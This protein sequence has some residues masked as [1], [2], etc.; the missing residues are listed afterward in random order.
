[1]VVGAY[2]RDAG[3]LEEVRDEMRR[4]DGVSSEAGRRWRGDQRPSFHRKL[5]REIPH[6]P[7][8]CPTDSPLFPRISRR[9]RTWFGIFVASA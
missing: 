9:C 3:S 1:M 2:V 5:G 6:L 4:S 8:A 7:G